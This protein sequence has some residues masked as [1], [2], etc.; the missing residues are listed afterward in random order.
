MSKHNDPTCDLVIVQC[1]TVIISTGE[2]AAFSG[3]SNNQCPECYSMCI[4]NYVYVCAHMILDMTIITGL[5]L[6][7]SPVF[8]AED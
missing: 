3:V 1:Q 8:S 4:K 6:L 5:T 7:F 2:V